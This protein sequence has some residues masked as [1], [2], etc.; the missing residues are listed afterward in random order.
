[1]TGQE[2][3]EAFCIQCVQTG[4]RESVLSRKA[5]ALCWDASDQAERADRL[6]FLRIAAT[7]PIDDPKFPGLGLAHERFEEAKAQHLAAYQ[8]DPAGFIDRALYGGLWESG[9]ALLAADLPPVYYVVDDFLPQGLCLLAA[10]PKFG[11]S[12]MCLSLC[13]EVARGG[14]FLN[15]KCSASPCLYLAL[16]DSRNRLQD[17][18]A[19]V[20]MGDPCPPGFSLA[21][22]ADTLG[23][24]LLLYL[25]TYMKRF[26]DS[27]MIVI[28]TLQKVRG[29]GSRP[30]SA[31]ADDYADM[32]ALKAFADR[33]G[34]CL[35]LVHHLRKMADDT[36]PFNRIAGSNGLFG[37]ADTAMVL[38]RSRRGDPQT[39]LNLT[40]RDVEEQ[41]LIVQFNK[42]TFR[43]ELLGDA[44]TVKAQRLQAEY[45]EN[46]I[47]CTINRALD[48]NGGAWDCTGAGF[49]KG[50]I[51]WYGNCP[52]DTPQALTKQLA[53]LA[54]LLLENDRIR[55]IKRGRG[56]SG[57]VHC[58]KRL[59]EEAAI[60]GDDQDEKCDENV[61][62]IQFCT[63]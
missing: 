57:K 24:G 18:L 44:E 62:I 1:M 45:E 38:T 31:Y 14:W 46:P 30:G 41:E 3:F 5:F 2:Q 7:N 47:V 52:A 22:K 12:W 16:E 19:K 4:D 28:D 61:K 27:K 49:I 51:A 60:F 40:G 17:R 8:A 43:W 29:G 50:C 6:Y 23:S 9:A 10:P 15:R 33:F 56:G 36:D 39:T 13:V 58:F 63:D 42:E 34:V 37:A 48:E 55:Y 21:T 54:P 59:S 25:E 11:K 53:E 35:L 20:L 26:P 32:G